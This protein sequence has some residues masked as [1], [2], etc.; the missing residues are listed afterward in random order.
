[1]K[2]TP[3]T[4]RDLTL[5]RQVGLLFVWLTAA[6]GIF[7][8]WRTV[9]LPVHI[10]TAVLLIALPLLGRSD[11]RAARIV[12]RVL[13]GLIWAV[14]LLF[15]AET[16]ATI[17]AGWSD[18]FPELAV[19]LCVMGGSLLCAWTPGVFTL[20]R[21]GGRYDWIVACF[22]QTLLAGITAIGAF[23]CAE[24]RV[25]WLWDHPYVRYVFF[26]LATAAAI[27]VWLCALVK[28][29]P[30]TATD[31]GEKRKTAAA[32]DQTDTTAGADT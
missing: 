26:G 31:A 30:Q 25:I 12:A 16:A 4:E 9:T 22:C 24:E 11:H 23:T 15:L 27:L 17:S 1:M 3:T 13:C 10:G 5:C 6:V 28:P 32:N 29:T 14:A 20:A 18:A 19:S 2:F 7:L 8:L 21:H